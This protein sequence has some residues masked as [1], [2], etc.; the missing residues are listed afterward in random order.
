MS[1]ALFHGTSPRRPRVRHGALLLLML[2]LWSSR[3][4]T[5]P[6]LQYEVTVLPPGRGTAIDPS[7][8]IVVGDQFTPAN[9]ASILFPVLVTL[10]FLPEGTSSSANA[11]FAGRV[12]GVSS[13]GTLALLSHAFDTTLEDRLDDLGTTGAPD[14]FSACTGL[15]ATKRVGF[16]DSPDR[17][18]IVPVV[19]EQGVVTIRPPL[20]GVAEANGF[21]EA[22]N[23]AGDECGESD[24][25]DGDTHATCWFTDDFTVPVDLDGE[26]GRLSFAHGL[27]AT[28]RVVGA[29]ST[30]HGV[31]CFVWDPGSGL[32]ARAPF[33]GDTQGA[34][35]DVNASGDVVGSSQLPDPDVAAFLHEAALIYDPD[36]TA[37]DLSTRVDQVPT[38]CRFQTAVAISDDGRIVVNGQC[39]ST[40][41]VFLL[42]PSTLVAEAPGRPGTLPEAEPPAEEPPPGL[43]AP[44]LEEAPAPGGDEDTL[45]VADEGQTPTRRPRRHHK[46]HMQMLKWM[47]GHPHASD[48]DK[49]MVTDAMAD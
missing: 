3:G 39:G 16:A 22:V 48:Y 40:P 28:R 7:G 9:T 45:P 21:I 18:R 20:G 13:T 46:R 37:I 24:T 27:N 33:P 29:V 2:L 10:G 30:T 11:V 32:V 38:G 26:P 43:D 42:T 19:F 25:A 8:T 36:G 47:Q 5:A 31:R 41:Q 23:A 4:W 34:C 15:N 17:G 1:H 6:A 12:C 49:R 35:N 14:L 44:A